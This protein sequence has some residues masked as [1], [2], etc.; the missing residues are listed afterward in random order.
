[1]LIWYKIMHKF[2][3]EHNMKYNKLK[4]RALHPKIIGKIYLEPNII[5][6][7]ANLVIKIK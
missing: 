2:S 4:V 1:M 5:I 6:Y 7:Y 3:C